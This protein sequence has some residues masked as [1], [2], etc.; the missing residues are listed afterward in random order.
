MSVPWGLNWVG[1]L[2]LECTIQPRAAAGHVVFEL[3]KGGRRFRCRIDLATGQ[4]TLFISARAEN[5]HPTA[6]TA[7]KDTR[8]H[9][10]LFAN[11]TIG[12]CFGS[13]AGSS[14]PAIRR[15]TA[16]GRRRPATIPRP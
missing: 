6:I 3:V 11:P 16:S 9:R 12:D 15:A 8:P 4:A 5:F 7:V 14:R 10:I 13:M 1:D 2:A